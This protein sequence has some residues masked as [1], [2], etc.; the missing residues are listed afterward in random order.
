MDT[1]EMGKIS[2]LPKRRLGEEAGL[3]E[4]FMGGSLIRKVQ[5]RDVAIA[6]EHNYVL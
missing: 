5:L 1:R 3:L 2:S 4:K 6:S